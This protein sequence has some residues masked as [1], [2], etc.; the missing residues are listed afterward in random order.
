MSV[1]EGGEIPGYILAQFGMAVGHKNVLS[2]KADLQL[3]SYDSAIDRALPSAVLFPENTEQV[4]ALVK[5]CHKHKI[6]FVARGA[7]TNLCGGTI[8]LHQ[9]VVIAPT[10]MKRILSVNPQKRVAVVEPGL[11]NLFLKKALEPYGLYYAPDP[12]SQKACT[13]GGNIG[14]NAG[15]PHCLKYGVTS[16][17]ILG[18]ELVL[19]DGAVIHLDTGQDG[20]DMVG[21]MVGSEGTLGIVTQATLNLLPLPEKVET[22]LAAFPSL[23]AAM[24]TVTEVITAGII[25]ATLEAMDKITVQAVEAFVHAGYPT[26]AEAVLLI[27]VDGSSDLKEEVH[28]IRT[29]CEKNRSQE[30]RLAVNEKEREKLW[31]GRR[32]SYPAMA[33][34]APNVLVEDGA[35]PRN[36]LPEASRRI[37]AI[38]RGKKLNLSLIFHAG[39][40]NLHPQILFDE[41]NKEETALVKSA[42][43]EMLKVC[44]DM[45]GTIS[46]EHGIGIDKREAMRWLFTPETLRLFRKI[47]RVFD[48]ENLCNPDKLI[49]L[50]EENEEQSSPKEQPD[51]PIQFLNRLLAPANEAELSATLRFLN[52]SR[53]TIF[54]EGRKTGLSNP[55]S[56]DVSISTQNLNR[57][58]EHDRENFTIIVEA[59]IGLDTLKKELSQSGQKVHVPSERNGSLGGLIAMNWPQTPPLR[60]QILGMRVALANGEI[61]QFGAKV[62]K[63]VAGYDAAKLLLGSRGSLGVILSVILKTYPLRYGVDAQPLTQTRP[64][65]SSENLFV[66]R[67]ILQKI[68]EAFDPNNSFVTP[69]ENS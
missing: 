53:K 43:Y 12:A 47:K 24:Q 35:V 20:S 2:K 29:I 16:H 57:I 6:P 23:D 17:H 51:S 40:G 42:G 19:P 48:P 50:P 13:I 49:P 34:L 46:G 62:M 27:E 55:P 58:V 67:R 33:R 37:R 3:Y 15:G 26:N 11:P 69:T 30:F 66:R 61:V 10:R 59:G 21:L 52:Q 68:K 7:G 32:G 31:E 45:G 9:S 22:M 65:E 14:T 64:E 36:R 5:I 39:D 54:I 38:A 60:D 44:V 8:P 63:N 1:N 28:K 56:S 4:S 25:P 18:L 41:R